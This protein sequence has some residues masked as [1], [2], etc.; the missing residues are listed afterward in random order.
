MQIQFWC[1]YIWIHSESWNF[2]SGFMSF[3]YW[4][5]GRVRCFCELNFQSPML[6]HLKWYLFL[7]FAN[8]L[9]PSPSEFDFLL[10]YSEPI[11]VPRKHLGRQFWYFGSIVGDYFSISGKPWRTM[12][13][14]ICFWSSVRLRMFFFGLCP[15]H[16]F[17]NRHFNSRDVQF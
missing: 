6:L 7:L 13:A 15:S 14:I 3:Q 9:K 11:L 17:P 8:T 12:G 5:I 4:P 10:T 2:V 1:P 16:I